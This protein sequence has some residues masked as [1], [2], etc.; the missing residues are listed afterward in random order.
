MATRWR[1]LSGRLSLCYMRASRTLKAHLKVQWVKFGLI[2]H[3]YIGHKYINKSI[4]S[5]YN[6]SNLVF[7]PQTSFDT[8]ENIR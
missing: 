6:I 7:Q 1:F 8:C 2:Y 5:Q 3:F 4:N